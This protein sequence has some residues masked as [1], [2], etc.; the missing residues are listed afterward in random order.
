M[1]KVATTGADFNVASLAKVIN[2]PAIT[3]LIVRTWLGKAY[4]HRRS[5]LVFAVNIDH[6]NT[7]V[8]E[9]TSRGIDARGIHS[10]M[11]LNE[12][13]MTLA[14]FRAG[15]FPVLINCGTLPSSCSDSHRRRRCSSD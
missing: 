13:R 4:T 14:A 3:E 1:S 2:R 7:L 6:V 8:A 10:G 9:F 5:T 12:R 15:E 11:P